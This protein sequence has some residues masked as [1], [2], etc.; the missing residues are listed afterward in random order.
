MWAV[1]IMG[2]SLAPSP[3]DR[4][5]LLSFVLTMRTTSAFWIGS[6]RQH[7]TASQYWAMLASWASFYYFPMMGVRSCPS[8]SKPLG[9]F[10]SVRS[11]AFLASLYKESAI[12]F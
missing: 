4:V 8:I 11:E 1:L 12:L 9:I 6:N 7:T 2:T 3:I 5:I 10:L